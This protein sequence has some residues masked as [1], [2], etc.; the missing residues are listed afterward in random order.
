MNSFLLLFVFLFD[1]FITSLRLL[2]LSY[3]HTHTHT[4]S[5]PVKIIIN[6]NQLENVESFKYLG[7]ILTNDGRCTCEITRRIATAKAA[8]NRKRA[9]F[10]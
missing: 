6:Q 4:K 2:R 7:R 8:F 10:Y 1:C 3:T 5:L 9:L